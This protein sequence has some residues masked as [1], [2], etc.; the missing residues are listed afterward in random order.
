VYAHIAGGS[1]D[2]KALA[3]NRAAFARL[4]IRNRVLVDCRA[5]HTAVELF[6][7]R[8]AHPVLLA[9]VSHHALVHPDGEIAT[10]QAA[11]AQET[12]MVVST[13][14]SVP[15]ER[16]AAELG[17]NRWFQ[18]YFQPDWR[19][20]EAL[21]ARAEAAGYTA[22]V[23]TVDAPVSG[24]RNRAERAGFV[25]PPHVWSANLESAEPRPPALTPGQS[26]IFQGAMAYAPT[27]DDVQRLRALTRLPILLKGVTHTDDARRAVEL[28]LDGIVVSNHGGRALDE[29]PAP[30]EVLASIRA[31]VGPD[32]PLL[33]DGGIRR[34]GDVFM[35][36]AL[37]ADAVL[38]GRPQ[39]YA[40]AVDGAIGVAR[41]LRLLRDELELTMALAGCPTV[42]DIDAGCLLNVPTEGREV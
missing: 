9:P 2:E 39:L 20:T 38:I 35:A 15:I 23:A 7:D 18:L 32:V 1:G 5:G 42:A 3:A 25:L 14:S 12:G 13:L 8:F 17:R 10:A 16:V 40:L 26:R 33:A 36:L 4:R 29:A 27:W 41:M 22:I 30:L 21:V 37:G 19:A 6:G 31:A 28:G 34:G 11:D 24:M